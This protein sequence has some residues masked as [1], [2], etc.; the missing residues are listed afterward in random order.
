MVCGGVNSI[1]QILLDRLQTSWPSKSKS[2]KFRRSED[3]V[4]RSVNFGSRDNLMKGQV[5]KV[6]DERKAK[7]KE[8]EKK[9]CLLR[10]G[11][12]VDD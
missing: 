5:M 10:C 4:M 9:V 12:G 2:R 8:E 1:W 11:V 7:E 6:E 3:E